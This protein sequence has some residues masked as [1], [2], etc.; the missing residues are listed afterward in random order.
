MKFMCL[1]CHYTSVVCVYMEV[2]EVKSSYVHGRL[3]TVTFFYIANV[4][5]TI[6]LLNKL[7]S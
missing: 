4:E 1:Y 6:S 3:G 2:K 7:D 5:D